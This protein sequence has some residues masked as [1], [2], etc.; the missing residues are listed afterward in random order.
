MKAEMKLEA[1]YY[2]LSKKSGLSSFYILSCKNVLSHYSWIWVSPV[3]SLA[4]CFCYVHI[5]AM[6]ILVHNIF[7]FFCI[8]SNHF[9]S[10]FLLTGSN[11][12]L[13]DNGRRVLVLLYL[14]GTPL[15]IYYIMYLWFAIKTIW[16]MSLYFWNNASSRYDVLGLQPLIKGKFCQ[17]TSSLFSRK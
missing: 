15:E 3:G 7:L 10:T 13:I 11:I 14:C 5:P 8:A 4:H 12:F 17:K 2:L 1:D 16:K 9:L 6:S